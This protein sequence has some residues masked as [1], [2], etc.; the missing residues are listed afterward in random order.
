MRSASAFVVTA[1]I[2]FAFG[3]I[4]SAAGLWWLR[5]YL[6][7]SAP[8]QVSGVLQVQSKPADPS[9]SGNPP[10]GYFIEATAIGRVYLEHSSAKQYVGR[11]VVS[12]GRLS[13]TCGNDGRPCYPEIAATSIRE[14]K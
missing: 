2:A 5:H 12:S 7:R 3:A 10:N 14:V 6:S 8:V 11:R 1:A 13:A 9:A 4:S